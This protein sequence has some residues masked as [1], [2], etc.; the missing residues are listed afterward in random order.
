NLNVGDELALLSAGGMRK[1][2][3]QFS[4]PRTYRFEV[5]G[6][7]SQIQIVEGSAIFIDKKAAQR[8][9]ELRNQVSGL[10]LRLTN[11][12]LA[13]EIQEKRRHDLGNNY[14]LSTWYDLRRR[15]HDIMYLA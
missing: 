14:A 7:Y 13:D 10:D 11:S 5:R 1:S 4:L 2:L 12:S 15:L 3:T 8:L 9:F 6:S